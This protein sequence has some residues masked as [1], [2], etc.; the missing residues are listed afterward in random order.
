MNDWYRFSG[1][2]IN[3]GKKNMQKIIFILLMLM[4]SNIALAE[5]GQW[6]TSS[7]CDYQKSAINSNNKTIASLVFN[8]VST[9]IQTD[10]DLF[11]L[12]SNSFDESI[13]SMVKSDDGIELQAY[14]LEISASNASDVVFSELIRKV[15][16]VKKG[17]QGNTTI[18]GGTGKYQGITGSCVYTA[19]YHPKNKMS[20]ISTCKYNR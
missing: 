5:S 15:G 3:K 6:T 2:S 9:I 4:G 17:G 14:N 11:P 13:A 10:N 18:V 16:D 1:L 19:K 20:Q 8:C 7:V 12:Y